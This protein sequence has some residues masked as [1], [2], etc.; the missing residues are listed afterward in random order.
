MESE[1]VAQEKL[2]RKSS[3]DLVKIKNWSCKHSH[4]HNGMG[5]TRIRTFPF[6]SDSACDSVVYNLVKS[7][8][9]ESE[10]EALCNWFRSFA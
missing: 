10:A 6:S 9:S 7:R 1:S 3:Y 5:F 2:S 4:E 8:L